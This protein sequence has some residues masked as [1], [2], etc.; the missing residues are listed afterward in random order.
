MAAR[1]RAEVFVVAATRVQPRFLPPLSRDYTVLDL[2]DPVGRD[3]EWDEAAVFEVAWRSVRGRLRRSWR[4]TPTER[5]ILRGYA[6]AAGI[7]VSRAKRRFLRRGVLQAVAAA[8]RR[9]FVRFGPAW[10]KERGRKVKVLPYRWLTGKPTA[11]DKRWLRAEGGRI[12]YPMPSLSAASVDTFTRWFEQAIFAAASEVLAIHAAGAVDEHDLDRRDGLDDQTQAATRAWLRRADHEAALGLRGEGQRVIRHV[13]D[14]APP[15]A[16]DLPS[17]SAHRW[18]LSLLAVQTFNR[19]SLTLP[20]RTYREVLGV[21]EP[22]FDALT[23]RVW[24]DERQR[25]R[26]EMMLRR[27][28]SSQPEAAELIRELVAE[29]RAA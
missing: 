13:G 10:V 26:I 16:D 14:R 2:I 5:L 17:T 1:L 4:L 21:F 6:D 22:I 3:A 7:G 24:H 11:R 19:L 15:D 12:L 29:L 18:E 28:R 8:K 9:Q 23:P 20:P 27:L 25:H